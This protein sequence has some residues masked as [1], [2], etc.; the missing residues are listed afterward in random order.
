MGP[1]DAD[2]AS[3]RLSQLF[4]PPGPRESPR[5]WGGAQSPIRPVREYVS[6]APRAPD[7]PRGA[8]R[9]GVVL[10][11]VGSGLLIMLLLMFLRTQ[12]RGGGGVGKLTASSWADS[13]LVPRPRVH[14]K[15]SISARSGA[16]P[17]CGC[18]R[19]VGWRTWLKCRNPSHWLPLWGVEIGVDIVN[20]GASGGLLL[21]FAAW[22]KEGGPGGG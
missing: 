18:C 19:T 20:T 5:G 22:A 15:L 1:S 2:A 7:D 16:P 11:K 8:R 17:R 6:P 9:R 13:T 3:T 4:R 21:D 10:G 12:Y 14:T